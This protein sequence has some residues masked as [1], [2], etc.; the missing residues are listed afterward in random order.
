[1][2][3]IDK[4]PITMLLLVINKVGLSIIQMTLIDQEETPIQNVNT[5]R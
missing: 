3:A 1:M 4:K 2:L 5:L